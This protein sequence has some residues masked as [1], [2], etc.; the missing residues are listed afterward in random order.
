MSQTYSGTVSKMAFGGEGIVKDNSFVTFIPFAAVGDTLIYS[1][2][3]EKKSFAKGQILAIDTPSAERVIPKCP[4]FGS[5][6]GCQLQHIGYTH[7]LAYK[8]QWIEEAL[9]RQAK[10][11]CAVPDV[12]PSS[13]QWH[14]RRKIVLTLRPFG[15]HYKVGYFRAEAPSIIEVKQCPIF[16]SQSDP[17]LSEVQAIVSQLS[18]TDASDAKLHILKSD[19]YLLYFHFKHLPKNGESIFRQAKER[20]SC[21]GGIIAK[22]QGHTIKIG[23]CEASFEMEDL[24]FRF[25]ADAFIQNNKGLSLKLYGDVAALALQLQPSKALDLYSGVGALTLL[26]AKRVS[27]SKIV[28]VEANQEATQYAVQNAAQNKLENA[29]FLNA[30]VEKVINDL[31]K[32]GQDL[33]IVNPPREGL[34]QRVIDAIIKSPPKTLIYISCMPS[35]LARDLQRLSSQPYQVLQVQGYDMF[36]QTTHV[37][38]VVAI[39]F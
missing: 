6:G 35:T 26:L 9:T 21:I 7:Q 18:P 29:T 17:I 28:G 27:R 34:D 5:C 2:T 15:N 37:E 20:L 4:Y 23:S 11:K 25:S 16:T 12:I 1:H 38:T 24:D 39:Q 22:A 33:V 30:Y 14:Y 19:H 10:L 3:Q 31:L 13:D 8:K 32:N 36:P